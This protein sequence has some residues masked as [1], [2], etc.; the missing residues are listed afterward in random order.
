MHKRTCAVSLQ[1]NKQEMSSFLRDE[2]TAAENQII[3]FNFLRPLEDVSAP[4]TGQ[5]YFQQRRKLNSLE[6]IFRRGQVVVVQIWL[7]A[8]EHEDVSVHQ[9]FHRFLQRKLQVLQLLQLVRLH[10][11]SATNHNSCVNRTIIGGLMV[12]I[13][14]TSIWAANLPP[15]TFTAFDVTTCILVRSLWWKFTP[16]TFL[17]W[18]R[19]NFDLVCEPFCNPAN[20]VTKTTPCHFAKSQFS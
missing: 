5:G 3:S 18:E 2:E 6:V 11:L 13:L 9:L 16:R 7:F 20:Q 8:L 19:S 14:N 17:E 4:K 10:F 1:N 12:A 15:A